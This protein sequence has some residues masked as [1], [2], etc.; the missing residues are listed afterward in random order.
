MSSRTILASSFGLVDPLVRDTELVW[1]V[2]QWD[3]LGP[4][5]NYVTDRAGAIGAYIVRVNWPAATVWHGDARVG[6]LDLEAAVLAC[7]TADDSLVIG[8]LAW[9]IAV[10]DRT[11][12]P[13]HELVA[14]NRVRCVTAW[15]SR[16]LARRIDDIEPTPAE[17]GS[18][19]L[20]RIDDLAEIIAGLGFDAHLSLDGDDYTPGDEWT[21][22]GLV[23]ACGDLTVVGCDRDAE[24]VRLA[25]AADGAFDVVAMSRTVDGRPRCHLHVA[26]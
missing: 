25:M 17:V 12:T 8:P 15:A 23:H 16:Q 2:S 13:P 20:A 5:G 22:I 24:A 21:L 11:A 6:E 14:A 3:R 18:E 9:T 4:S 1:A 7:G 26:H 19:V 10:G